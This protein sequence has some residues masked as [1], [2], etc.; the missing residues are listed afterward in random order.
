MKLTKRIFASAALSVA[1]VAPAVAPVAG[2]AEGEG[3]LDLS[4]CE[5]RFK[6]GADFDYKQ[7]DLIIAAYLTKNCNLSLEEISKLT[8]K[9]L[10]EFAKG[11]EDSKGQPALTKEQIEG[12]TK[13]PN[14]HEV[15]PLLKKDESKPAADSNDQGDAAQEEEQFIVSANVHDIKAGDKKVTGTVRL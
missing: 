3:K 1:L 14:P 2:A 8:P 5:Q 13:A 10:K 7:T 4:Q 12:I 9:E 11:L 6:K 15:G